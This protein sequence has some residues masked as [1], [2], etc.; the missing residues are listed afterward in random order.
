MKPEDL[1]STVAAAKLGLGE[2]NLAKVKIVN[3]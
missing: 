1:A 2:M 3:A